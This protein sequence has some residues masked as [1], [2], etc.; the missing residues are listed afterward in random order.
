MGSPKK[1]GCTEST[2]AESSRTSPIS[3]SAVVLPPIQYPIVVNQTVAFENCFGFAAAAR[4][5]YESVRPFVPDDFALTGPPGLATIA[6]QGSLCERA[7]VNSIAV[8]NV[9]IL[10]IGA[11]VLPEEDSW[12][13]QGP[14]YYM[15]DTW[16]SA[17]ALTQWLKPTGFPATEGAFAR[18]LVPP[19]SAAHAESWSIAS[20][21][22][23]VGVAFEVSGQA[24]APNH[25][26]IAQWYGKKPYQRIESNDQY[27]IDPLEHA[28]GLTLDGHCLSQQAVGQAASYTVGA[29]PEHSAV[30]TISGK[31]YG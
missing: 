27:T 12:M 19:S 25:A 4:V 28:S 11:F 17:P 15:F 18:T 31:L 30:W 14:N 3:P 29:N 7:V 20:S 21:T 23:H 13:T 6:V 24:G 22:C 16:I 9:S 5:P 10:K 8:G 2:C 1:P 26:P